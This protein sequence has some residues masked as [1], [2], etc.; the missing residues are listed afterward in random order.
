LK[1]DGKGNKFGNSHLILDAFLKNNEIIEFIKEYAN[2]KNLNE[3]IMNWKEIKLLYLFSSYLCINNIEE[4]GN[5]SNI[6]EKTKNKHSGNNKHFIYLKFKKSLII[7]YNINN[8][9]I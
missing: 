5:I 3:D 2:D 4:L 8:I 9:Y 7:I 1:I 6:E